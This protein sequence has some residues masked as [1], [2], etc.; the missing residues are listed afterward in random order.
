VEL[1]GRHV[2]VVVRREVVEP[3]VQVVLAHIHTEL[4][5]ALDPSSFHIRDRVF[6]TRM[7]DECSQ[8]PSTFVIWRTCSLRYAD[9]APF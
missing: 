8:L 4:G 2:L 5:Q 6:G 9:I 1:A 7:N 3:V